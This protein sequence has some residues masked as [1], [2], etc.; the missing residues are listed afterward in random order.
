MKTIKYWIAR[1]WHKFL[2]LKRWQQV[3]VVVLIIA[4]YAMSPKENTTT[5]ESVSATPTVDQSISPQP[6][7]PV[8]TTVQNEE[9]STS[10][11]TVNAEDTPS[12]SPSPRIPKLNQVARDGKFAFKVTKVQC[13]IHKVGSGSFSSTA[14]GQYCA[15]TLNVR[16]DGDEPQTMFSSNQYLYDKKERKFEADS[17]AELWAETSGVSWEEINPGNSVTGTI[18][19]D[20]P[21]GIKLD[22]L[23]V[24][25]SMFSFGTNI[26]LS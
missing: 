11:S 22:Y 19:F 5:S 15:I 14:Q 21:V 24:H 18:Y 2:S 16:N 25:D 4:F 17:S 8:D 10:P 9:P 1:I 12:A 20:V 7:P 26:Y 6:T 3:V 13:G 23:E